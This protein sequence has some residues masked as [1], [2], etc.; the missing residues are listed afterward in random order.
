MKANKLPVKIVLTGGP[1]GGKTTA[2]DLMSREFPTRATTVI[3][4]ATVLY[5]SGI[6]R[7]KTPE[8]MRAVQLAIYNTQ[9][10][11]ENLQSEL[12]PGLVLLCDRGTCD[13]AAYWPTNGK[14]FFATLGTTRQEEYHRYDAVLFFET[15]AAGKL[16]IQGNN[17]YRVEDPEQAKKIDASLK[18]VW[19]DHPEFHFI[20]HTDSF[21]NKLQAA[22][23]VIKR[24]L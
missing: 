18:S 11:L 3:E 14:D 13:G 24:W 6:P 9:I 16:S 20:K 23:D 5:G 12:N 7:A 1:G 4:A 15:A 10:A 8:S 2:L 22:M 19:H 17:P 21:F